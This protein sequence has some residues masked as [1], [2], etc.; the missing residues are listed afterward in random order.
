MSTIAKL[1]LIPAILV[2]LGVG[3]A[4][5]ATGGDDGTTSTLTA[6]TEDGT[7]TGQTGT[8]GDDVSG[9]C[10]EAEHANDPRCT[11]DQRPEDNGTGTGATTTTGGDISGPCDE[12]EHANDPRCTGA[13]GATTTTPVP[14]AART[15]A[16]TTMTTTT[17][18]PA[19]RAPATARA[20]TTT[21]TTT[22]AATAAR[23]VAATARTTSRRPPSPRERGRGD[24]PVAFVNG[25]R[26]TVARMSQQPAS[27][28]RRPRP[29][30]GRGGPLLLGPGSV[31]CRRVRPDRP[32]DLTLD[33]S[34]R[35]TPES[36][37]KPLQTP[38]R[39]LTGKRG[40]RPRTPHG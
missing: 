4:F 33:P 18:V 20:A 37:K 3:L 13:G 6:T 32:S 29:L 14:A 23:V 38:C 39:A 31:R 28:A 27:R 11:G 7:T 30:A 17:R 21:T 1:F 9:P 8:G 24:A 10:D 19:R 15:T 2:A 16:A 35:A 22:R 5:A 26:R 34:Q 40:P 25:R 12:A 36:R